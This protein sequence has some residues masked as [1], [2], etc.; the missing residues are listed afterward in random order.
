MKVDFFPGEASFIDEKTLLIKSE[1][2]QRQELKAKNYVIATGSIPSIFPGV[3]VD[4]KLIV[5]STGALE[6]DSIP[7][8]LGI[9]GAG[10]IGLE[11]VINLYRFIFR[12]LS[13]ID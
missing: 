10:I 13:G 6:F 9:I 2:D 7:K 11:L 4:E 1:A 5:T 12:D 3:E 8:K